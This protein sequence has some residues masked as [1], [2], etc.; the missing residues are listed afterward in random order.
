MRLNGAGGNPRCRGCK[1]LKVRQWEIKDHLVDYIN[2]SHFTRCNFHCG[3]CY[4]QKRGFEH[5]KHPYD[6]YETL[7]WMIQE[8]HLAPSAIVSWGGGEPVLLKNFDEIFRLLSAQGAFQLMNT[9]GSVFSP[10]LAEGLASNQRVEMICSLDAGCRETFHKVKGKDCFD[11]SVESLAR[12]VRAAPRQC[13]A[14]FI[15]MPENSNAR[16][17]ASFVET[18]RRAGVTRAI[19]DSDLFSENPYVHVQN[20]ALMRHLFDEAGVTSTIEMCGTD[21]FPD[22]MSK[23]D[24]AYRA[25]KCAAAT[26]RSGA[27]PTR[28]GAK[29]DFVAAAHELTKN[30]HE[31]ELGG[32]EGG[33][34]L[35]NHLHQPAPAAA[36]GKPSPRVAVLDEEGRHFELYGR[37]FDLLGVRP[38]CRHNQPPEQIIES[39]PDVILLSREWTLDW[40][41]CAAAARRA[42]IPVIYVMDGVIEWSYVWNNLSFVRPQGTMLQPM[43]ASDLCVIGRHPARILAGW[44]LASR[45]HVVG[46]PRYDNFDRTRVVD[47]AAARSCVLITTAKTYAHDVE[48]Q[49]MVLRALRDLRAWF[50]SNSL[51]EPVWRIAADL[52]EE[53]GVKPVMRGSLSAALRAASALITFP[54]TCALEGMLKGLPV[55]QVD[56]RPV[57]SYV[58]SAWEI[59]SAEH[60]PNV[61]QELLYP[62]PAKLAYQD[63]CLADELEIGDASERLAEVIRQALSRRD[64]YEVPAM[65]VTDSGSGRLDYRQIHSELSAFAA[66]PTALIQ[67]ELDAAYATIKRLKKEKTEARQE[68]LELAEVLGNTDLEDLGR[69]LFIDH[70]SEGQLVAESPGTSETGQITHGGK[71]SRT[72]FLHPPARLSFKVP[73]NLP[74]RLS[75]AVMLHPDAWNK[76]DCGPCRFIVEADGRRLWEVTVDPSHEPADRRWRRFDVLVPE[77]TAGAHRFTFATEGIGSNA[78]RWAFWRTPVFVWSTAP[79][80]A[81]TLVADAISAPEA[82]GGGTDQCSTPGLQSAEVIEGLVD[83]GLE[84]FDAFSFLDRFSEGKL[85]A[86]PPGTASK[87]PIVQDGKSVQTLFLHPP[88]RLE[89]NVQSG[90]P[91]RLC[92]GIGMHP[93]AWNKPEA[94]A[95]RFIAEVSGEVVCDITIDPV[96]NPHD[97]RWFWF[98]LPVKESQIGK[99]QFVFITEAVGST[100][101]RWALW[102]KPLFISEKNLVHKSKHEEFHPVTLSFPSGLLGFKQYTQ[103]VLN[104]RAEESPF[105]RLSASEKPEVQ[106]VVV[107]PAA[108]VTDYCP[109]ISEA[110]A[111]ELEITDPAD[112]A[113]L[114]LVISALDGEGAVNLRSPIIFNRLTLKAKQVAL[115]NATQYAE[116]HPLPPEAVAPPNYWTCQEISKVQQRLD[117]RVRACCMLPGLHWAA[118]EALRN[119]RELNQK[120]TC[121]MFGPC[122]GCAFLRTTNERPNVHPNMIDIFTNSFCSVRCW[123]CEYTRPGGLP[124]AP[125]EL[126]DDKCG[127]EQRILNTQDIP[128]FIREFAADAGGNLKT[129]SLS[130]GDSA[131]HP[132][133]REIVR[134]AAESGVKV[135]YLSAGVLPPQTE[136]FCIEEIRCGRMFLSVSPDASKAETWAGIK[137]RPAVLWNRV[138]SFVSRSAQA[139]A[140]CVIVKIILLHENLLEVGDFVRFWHQQGVRRFALSALFG[141]ADKQLEREE[142]GKAIQTARSAI[143]ELEREFGAKLHFETIAL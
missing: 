80:E 27:T 75:F 46:L 115:N 84:M 94:G 39:R 21:R 42:K 133:F 141:H 18:C 105:L 100:A 44:G 40:R 134:T 124:D 4:T 121:G 132:Q 37:V 138:A 19:L 127:V 54:S 104:G 10:A 59:R 45:I 128:T 5:V 7:Q 120:L 71:T 22:I 66:A 50:A 95:C 13:M 83:H 1:W 76:S 26:A 53:L 77:T 96:H 25:L 24:E 98:D 43:T 8:H 2:F 88:A 30:A 118:G 136:D 14:K 119:K 112:A 63:S 62:P 6:V 86:Q 34:E 72:L 51:V 142:Y 32:Q 67:Y 78:Y 35:E 114:N 131:Y 61:I 103:F 52:A 49:M 135:V 57:P 89:F 85:T 106:F 116:D 48:Q 68:L 3:Y 16:E 55:A 36:V 102:R 81:R 23:V 73:V 130:G 9:N 69:F 11:Q 70:F 58:A 12:Y 87:G 129:I 31:V 125:P 126:R 74:G 90:R 29:G 28:E 109:D 33:R 92:F 93:D 140:D 60:I 41:L 122:T 15:F 65:P 38:E 139:N 79:S 111:E 101:Y 113:V 108:V 107:T 137:A 56:Y 123:Y 143:E 99:H 47:A 110:D 20:M 117:G 97:R 82:L 64:A 17:V 91:G